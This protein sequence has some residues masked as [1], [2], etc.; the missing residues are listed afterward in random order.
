V[1]GSAS[2]VFLDGGRQAGTAAWSGFGFDSPGLA[3]GTLAPNPIEQAAL[4]QAGELT[5]GADINVAEGFSFGIA[6]SN[7]RNSELATGVLQPQE[8]T[9]SSV[10]IFATYSDGGL[11]ADGYAGTSDQQFGIERSAQGDF[12]TNYASAIGQSDGSQTFGGL[13]LGYAW[14]VARGFEMGPVASLDYVRSNIGGYDE[15]GAGSF[16]LAVADR[17]FTSLGAK[18]GAMASFDIRTGQSSAIK[19]FGSVAYARELADT[20]DV[21]TARFFGAA[22][23]PFTIVNQLDGQWV[24]INAGAEMEL[25]QNL[26]AAISV[27]SDRGRGL[28][29][30]DQ[31]QLSLSW[32]F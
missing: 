8:D 20:A 12:R 25:G 16:G 27:T 18:A 21:V 17:S 14:D 13:R 11:F 29:S 31:G 19:A 2:G 1:F 9:S 3:S 7:L 6:V 30:N 24:S 22:D 26:R 10:A 4:T 15:L 23:T 32:R 5:V 28:L